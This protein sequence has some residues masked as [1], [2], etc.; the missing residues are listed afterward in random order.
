[1]VQLC[2]HV[3]VRVRA[4]AISRTRTVVLSKICPQSSTSNLTQMERVLHERMPAA[5]GRALSG[6]LL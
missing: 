5:A 2:Y 6:A 1:M 4:G 3:F